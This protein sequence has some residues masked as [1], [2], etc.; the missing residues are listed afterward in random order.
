M[1]G[2]ILT[3]FQAYGETVNSAKFSALLQ[4]QLNPAIRHKRWGLLSKGVLLLHDN[5]RLHMAQQ[6]Y[7]LCNG[8]DLNCF[9]IPLWSRS[10]TVWLH[11]RPLKGDPAWSQVWL[12]WWRPASSADIA[13]WATEKLFF[14]KG[15]RSSLNDTRSASLCR[16]LCRKVTRAFVL[17]Q[18][19]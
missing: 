13:S 14:L 15:W 3:K 2:S 11:L 1:R 17:H 18:W 12:A 8:L 4:D 19:N 6:R 9:H 7:R 16:G 10:S 5:A